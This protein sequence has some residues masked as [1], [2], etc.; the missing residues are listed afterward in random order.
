MSRTALCALAFSLPLLVSA[1]PGA[2]SA[3]PLQLPGAQFSQPPAGAPQPA[4]IAPSPSVPAPVAPTSPVAPAAPIPPN[5]PAAERAALPPPADITQ[6]TLHRDAR[7]GALDIARGPQGG[8]V[9]TLTL[10]GQGIANPQEACAVT[11]A[12]GEAGVALQ[13]VT[14]LGRYARYRLAAPACPVVVT[15]F[16]DAALLWTEGLCTFEAAD[17]RVDASGMWGPQPEALP[18]DPARLERDLAE[19]DEAVR[20]AFRTLSER[21]EGDALRAVLAEQAGFSAERVTTCA[22][23]AGEDRQGLCAARW[24]QARAAALQERLGATSAPALRPAASAPAAATPGPA[25]LSI[26]PNDN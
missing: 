2:A 7:T 5:A 14:P 24:T 11:I 21:S 4:P 20:A 19:A 9:A 25:P 15:L 23:Y 10:E 1:L 26:L 12:D 18:T 6:L 16:A 8:L 17:C 13:P 3:Q 22:R